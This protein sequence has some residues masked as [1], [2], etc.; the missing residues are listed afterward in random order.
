[1]SYRDFLIEVEKA[2]E[3]AENKKK[4]F[5][6]LVISCCKSEKEAYGIADNNVSFYK[7]FCYYLSERK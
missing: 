5:V 2:R 4:L 6:W 1:M 3:L 7:W